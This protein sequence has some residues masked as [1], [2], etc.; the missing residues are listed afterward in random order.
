LEGQSQGHA[1]SNYTKWRG[2]CATLS[3]SIR[4]KGNIGIIIIIIIIIMRWRRK[5][6]KKGREDR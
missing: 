3:S 1:R 5:G 6:R 4:G 2:T